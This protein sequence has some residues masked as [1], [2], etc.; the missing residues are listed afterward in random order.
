MVTLQQIPLQRSPAPAVVGM[1]A[2][3]EHSPQG[4]FLTCYA[5]L[6]QAGLYCPSLIW[7][8]PLSSR[9]LQDQHAV[10]GV[11][12]FRRRLYV[13]PT[14]LGCRMTRQCMSLV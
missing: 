11:L 2:S 3:Q 9:L 4:E 12:Q 10:P 8:S 6:G 1:L 14:P 5:C 13:Q 7:T